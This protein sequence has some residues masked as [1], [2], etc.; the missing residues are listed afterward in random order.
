MSGFIWT[1]I[2]GRWHLVQ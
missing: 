1:R 2:K